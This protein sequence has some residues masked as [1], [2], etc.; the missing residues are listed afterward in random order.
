[1]KR[2]L[3]RKTNDVICLFDVKEK[4]KGW[5]KGMMKSRSQN[6]EAETTFF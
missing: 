1:L 4:E 5:P 3:R 2:K 6:E